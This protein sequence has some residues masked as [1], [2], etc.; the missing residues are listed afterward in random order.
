MDISQTERTFRES[1]V[2]LLNAPN[3]T[4]AS[5]R[6]EI[7]IGK[8]TEIWKDILQKLRPGPSTS[9]FNIGCGFSYLSDLCADY[10]R[11]QNIRLTIMDD[12]E[13]LAKIRMDWPTADVATT[14]FLEGYFPSA[15]PWHDWAERKFDSILVYSVVHYV[16]EP[17]AFVMRVAQLLASGGRLLIGDIP[18]PNK[19]AR[20]LSSE[21]GRKFQAQYEKVD[22]SQIPSFKNAD[23][24]LAEHGSQLNMRV[25]DSFVEQITKACHASGLEVHVPPQD[26]KLP[27]SYTRD[28]ILISRYD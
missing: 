25:G 18:N 1:F 6:N 11:M 5:G 4:V 26:H 2:K 23:A 13:I 21:F 12:Q 10:C 27:F 8:E 22:I 24:Y 14:E 7:D 20:F 9:F 3:K 16:D 28:D 17:V 15:Y 19:R